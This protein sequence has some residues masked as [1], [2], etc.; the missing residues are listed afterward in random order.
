MLQQGHFH[1]HANGVSRAKGSSAVASAAYQSG[2]AMTHRQQLVSH[3][4]LLIHADKP[5]TLPD[6]TRHVLSQ[7]EISEEVRTAFDAQGITLSETA[8]SEKKKDGGWQ[9][10]NGD[11][12]YHISRV[13][14]TDELSL[15]HRKAI[16]KGRITDA[17]HE[18][19]Q[20]A[21]IFLSPNATVAKDVDE[22]G[23][24]IRRHWTIIDGN[25]TYGIRE[26]EKKVVDPEAELRKTDRRVLHIYADR[27]HRF[28]TREDVAE[29]W[30][31]VP[32]HAPSWLHTVQAK[33]GAVSA[34]E[35]EQIWNEVER[36]DKAM[37]SKSAHRL[38]LSF[39]RDLIDQEPGD[40]YEPSRDGNRQLLQRFVKEQFTNKGV[41]VDVAIHTPLAK[42]GGL[43]R[44]A[45]LLISTRSIREDGS[46]DK[47]S[48]YWDKK[49]R[50]EE[51]RVAWAKLQNHALERAGSDI[52]VHPHSYERQGLDIVPEEHLGPDAHRAARGEHSERV[53]A[54]DE[55][56]E[57]NAQRD[58]QCDAIS[59]RARAPRYSPHHEKAY[60]AYLERQ[61]GH[62]YEP[63]S[64]TLRFKVNAI[65]RAEKAEA[66][67]QRR[68]KLFQEKEHITMQELQEATSTTFSWYGLGSK[69]SRTDITRI[70]PDWEAWRRHQ[71][72]QYNKDNAFFAAQETR[73]RLF[74][75]GSKTVRTFQPGDSS[76]SRRQREAL[77]MHHRQRFAALAS[78]FDSTSNDNDRRFLSLLRDRI[79]PNARERLRRLANW[80]QGEKEMPSEKHRDRN[81]GWER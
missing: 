60:Y 46:F 69:T 41:I 29:T 52:R 19:L 39:V 22:N 5:F 73:V 17:L 40:P 59:K 77:E 27:R 70:T 32:D 68:V 24:T 43:N 16:N 28:K 8:A 56:R 67:R 21:N 48:G 75:L 42:D 14:V 78:R 4:E 2:Q 35:R 20:R 9:I 30:I 57:Q 51:W 7:G 71:T 47:K 11:E 65:V 50:V 61:E 44:H 12:T 31:A 66:Q 25:R 53:A 72:P 74:G 81:R 6:H 3:K 79:L 18:D 76:L 63:D 33:E 38:Q 64:A 62:I 37:D 1:V 55:I 23:R 15:E 58:T 13:T 54:N 36:A 10:A 34:A 26:H 49:A 80:W 45:H